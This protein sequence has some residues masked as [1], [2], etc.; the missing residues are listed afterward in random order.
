MTNQQKKKF[1]YAWLLLIG[2]SIMVAVIY[3]KPLNVLN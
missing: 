1:H 2:L 3:S